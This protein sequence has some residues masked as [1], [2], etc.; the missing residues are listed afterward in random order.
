MRLTSFVL[1]THKESSS[2]VS[3]PCLAR[4]PFDASLPTRLFQLVLFWPGLVWSGL[5]C[6]VAHLP[7]SFI[8]LYGN[9]ALNFLCYH[10]LLCTP[11]SHWRKGKICRIRETTDNENC[12]Q[13][14]CCLLR[15]MPGDNISFF[16][17]LFL[18]VG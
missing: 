13:E 1:C 11:R 4:R 9:V 3:S 5:F 6:S 16:F 2:F 15:A 12:K 14:K 17:L 7:S 18:L 10:F 8:P